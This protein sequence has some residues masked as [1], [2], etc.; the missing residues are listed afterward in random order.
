M[1]HHVLGAAASA[2]ATGAAGSASVAG[3]SI[4]GVKE[5]MGYGARLAS[6]YG[7]VGRTIES[8]FFENAGWISLGAA[9]WIA[10]WVAQ[11]LVGWLVWKIA[12]CGKPQGSLL[13]H[14]IPE[15]HKKQDVPL[16]SIRVEGKIDQE[17]LAQERSAQERPQQQ[18]QQQIR[19]RFNAIPLLIQSN[20]WRRGEPSEAVHLPE[21]YRRDARLPFVPQKKE[22][23]GKAT[24]VRIVYENAVRT[25]VMCLRIA[26]VLFATVF[27]FWMC[28]VSFVSLAT[29]LGLVSI[30]FSLAAASQISNVFAGISISSTGK[31]LMH[32]FIAANGELGE[33][34]DFNSQWVD[35]VNR[36]SPR[37]GK[38]RTQI[39]NTVIMNG[40]V[41]IYEDG[42]PPFL[43]ERM[44]EELTKAAALAAAA[45]AAQQPSPVASAMQSLATQTLATQTLATQTSAGSRFQ[46]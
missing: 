12:M 27:A 38:K 44:N 3:A 30:T 42:P 8:R 19:N 6:S 23:H 17:R 9:I 45:S 1:A 28:G 26:V 11:F 31:I 25:F 7:V 18:Q 22:W 35:I 21:A 43:I 46:K 20:G 2:A 36:F 41:T 33:V 29:S 4:G 24:R 34:E 39:P 16:T 10:G 40:N 5:A 14:I 13:D 32:D 15:D 37:S